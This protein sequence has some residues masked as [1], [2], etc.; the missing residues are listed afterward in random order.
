MVETKITQESNARLLSR[1]LSTTSSPV[2]SLATT[3]RP[4]RTTAVAPVTAKATRRN[5]GASTVRQSDQSCDETVCSTDS[6]CVNDYE[7]SGSRCHCNLGKG[8]ESCSEGGFVRI[9]SRWT[10][11]RI[12]ISQSRFALLLGH[13]CRGRGN[14]GLGRST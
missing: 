5:G 2:T 13:F 10:C 14:F 9:A 4:P 3:S 11:S 6:F 12:P 7:R 1:L 8:G